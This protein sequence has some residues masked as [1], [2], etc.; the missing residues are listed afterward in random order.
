MKKYLLPESGNFYKA[1]LHGHSTVS[2][3]ALTPEELKK[4]YMEKGYSIIAYTDHDVMI[5]HF[6]LQEE[7]FLPLIGFEMEFNERGKTDFSV[8]KTAHFCFI[9]LSPDQR[10]QPNKPHDGYL[11]GHAKEYAHLVEYYDEPVFY[12]NFTAEKINAAIKSAKEKGFFVTYNH[13]IWSLENRE[14]YLTYEGM[15]AMEICNY[16]CIVVGYNDKNWRLHVSA[17]GTVKSAGNNFVN[18]MPLDVLWFVV[19]ATTACFEN[20]CCLIHGLPLHKCVSANFFV[21]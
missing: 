17:C 8:T 13:P 10:K 3:G 7:N 16:G 2:D 18:E 6:D 4:I 11:F 15:D 20:L 14:S 12:R 1:N 21:E 9:A 19:F 5:P